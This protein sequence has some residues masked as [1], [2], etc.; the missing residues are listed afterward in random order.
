MEL[1]NIKLGEIA[2]KKY[3]TFKILIISLN[4]WNY[5]DNFILFR[6]Y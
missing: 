4:L 2:N 1:L 6:K 5:I 3:K